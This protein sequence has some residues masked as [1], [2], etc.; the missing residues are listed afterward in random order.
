MAHRGVNSSSRRENVTVFKKS[1]RSE[2]NHKDKQEG[3]T[4]VIKE[5]R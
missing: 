1:D 4:S 5:E 3:R 2:L